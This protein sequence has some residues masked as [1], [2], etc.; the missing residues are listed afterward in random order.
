EASKGGLGFN[1][2]ADAM[3]RIARRT[4]AG[5]LIRYSRADLTLAPAAGNRVDIKAGG[6]QAAAGIRVGF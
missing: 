5:G 4:W 1:V 3:W 2:G 6:V